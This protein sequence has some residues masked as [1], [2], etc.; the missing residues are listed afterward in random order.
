MIAA[1]VRIR[2]GDGG[3]R[4]SMMEGSRGGRRGKM[5]SG[6]CHQA[7]ARRS[8]TALEMLCITLTGVGHF[9]LLTAPRNEIG[10]WGGV[11]GE[12]MSNFQLVPSLDCLY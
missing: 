7:P 1:S 2:G 9:S 11:H 6:H 4:R 8:S 12:M 3:D 5:P 10:K